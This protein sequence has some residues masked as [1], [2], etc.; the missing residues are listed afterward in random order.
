MRNE[1]ASLQRPPALPTAKPNIPC[2]TS[3]KP[4]RNT[5]QL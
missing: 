2:W 3:M 5:V 4:K 1:G